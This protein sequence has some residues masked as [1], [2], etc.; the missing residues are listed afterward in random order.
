MILAKLIRG[1]NDSV[2]FATATPAT[3]ATLKGDN[4]PTVAKVATVN[5]ATPAKPNCAPSD[6][7]SPRTAI[8][9][10]QTTR[11]TADNEKAI[12]AWLAH[13]EETDPL[14]IQSV[15]S[16]CRQ[17]PGALQYYLGRAAEITR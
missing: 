8:R 3:A 10:P 7:R 4:G 17:D 9:H 14:E 6:S 12:R 5:V 1:E 15:L 2:R 13:I 16:E 11:M